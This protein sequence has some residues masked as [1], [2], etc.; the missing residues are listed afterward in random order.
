[1]TIGSTTVITYMNE[2]NNV[3]IPGKEISKGPTKIEN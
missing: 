2:G 3:Y 1:M